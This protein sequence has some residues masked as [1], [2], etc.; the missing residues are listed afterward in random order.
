[1]V[2]IEDGP[3]L[4]LPGSIFDHEYTFTD[5]RTP[6]A[7][8]SKRW[9]RVADSCDVK[10]APGQNPVVVAAATVALDAMAHPAR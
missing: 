6:M 2:K 4:D 9:F 5:G 3:D 7:T 1:M 10:T 8:V